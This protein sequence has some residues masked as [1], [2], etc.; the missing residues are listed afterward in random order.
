[1]TRYTALIAYVFAR[2][3]EP[4]TMAALAVVCSLAGLHVNA[5][6]LQAVFTLATLIFSGLGV[7][8]KEG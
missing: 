1:M 3:K 8:V 6:V 5:E 4:S 7:M 2:L